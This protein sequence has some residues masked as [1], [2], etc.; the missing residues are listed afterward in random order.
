MDPKGIGGGT[1][2]CGK[3]VARTWHGMVTQVRNSPYYVLPVMPAGF[4]VSEAKLHD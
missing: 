1:V 2:T 4:F 3:S